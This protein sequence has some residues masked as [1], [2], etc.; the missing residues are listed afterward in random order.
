MVAVTHPCHLGVGRVCVVPVGHI[1][2]LEGGQG[3]RL[4]LRHLLL[5]LPEPRLCGVP[6]PQRQGVAAAWS[7]PTSVEP[8]TAAASSQWQLPG[9]GPEAKA[10]LAE[11]QR[12]AE[13]QQADSNWQKT[14]AGANV[15]AVADQTLPPATHLGS[16]STAPSPSIIPIAFRPLAIF[17]LSA[18]Q[19]QPGAVG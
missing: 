17:T 14:G 18:A 2:V 13:A 11:V 9:G 1:Q 5:E 7:L 19:Q 10:Q 6:A 16:S 12:A 3:P 15:L 4:E 8:A